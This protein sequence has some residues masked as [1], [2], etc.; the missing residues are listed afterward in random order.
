VTLARVNGMLLSLG[1][2]SASMSVPLAASDLASL[3]FRS[4][5]RRRPPALA[6]ADARLDS[7][8]WIRGT[9]AGPSGAPVRIEIGGDVR[10]TRP[11]AAELVVLS[12]RMTDVASGTAP[13]QSPSLPRIRFSIP[14]FVSE[15]RIA[16]GQAMVTTRQW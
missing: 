16:G 4:S 2:T 3:V 12:M 10:V 7:L 1:Q 14:R 13:A 8:L 11:G 6:D 5:L 9:V 15:I